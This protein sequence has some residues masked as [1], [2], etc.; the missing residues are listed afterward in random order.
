MPMKPCPDCRPPGSGH[1]K[2]T[3]PG[4][5]NGKVQVT[6]RVCNGRGY[7]EIPKIPSNWFQGCSNC[8]GSQEGPTTGFIT[9]GTGKETANCPHCGGQGYFTCQRCNGTGLIPA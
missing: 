9:M 5:D 1:Q 7:T 6:C 4:C 8:G 2:C 3:H